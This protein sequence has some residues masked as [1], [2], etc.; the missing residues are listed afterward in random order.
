MLDEGRLGLAG[1][2]LGVTLVIGLLAVPLGVRIT[3]RLAG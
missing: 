2:Y 1:V 3:R